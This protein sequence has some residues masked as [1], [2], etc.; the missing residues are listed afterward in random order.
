MEK[1]QRESLIAGHENIREMFEHDLY[2]NRLRY[3]AD[4]QE[5]FA[6]V[7]EIAELAAAGK[8]IAIVDGS[9]DVPQPQHQ[10]FLHHCRL[11]AARNHFKAQADNL[12]AEYLASSD[13][14]VLIVT[15]DTDE[16]LA[17]LKGGKPE[18]GGIP[19]PVY[20]WELR[21]QYI[22]NF[23]TTAGDDRFRPIVDMITIDGG[24]SESGTPHES[25][26]AFGAA[27]AGKGSLG[28]WVFFGE[29]D[30]KIAQADN[31]LQSGGSN[32]ELCVIPGDLVYAADASG[33]PW[34]SSGIIRKIRA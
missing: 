19:R 18:K 12:T 8:H 17:D 15:L 27:L 7:D 24:P 4:S 30:S 22:A 10:W 26:L 33:V 29:H 1:L 21:A 2:K 9:F 34:K 32:A 16:R 5:S 3:P 6:I 31:I 20:P 28:S 11:I 14:V 13:E 23:M 25:H